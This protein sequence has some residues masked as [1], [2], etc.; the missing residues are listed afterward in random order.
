[1][2]KVRFTKNELKSRRD[3]L[4]LYKRFLPTLQ[5]KKKQLLSEVKQLEIRMAEKKEEDR[6]IRN[7]IAS[8]VKLFSEEVLPEY[9]PRIKDVKRGEGNIAGV[10]IPVLEDVAFTHAQIDLFDTP[11]WLDSA[12]SAM[13]TLMK[14]KIELE[15]MTEQRRLIDD[16]LTAT[17]QRVNLFE[18]VKIPEAKYHICAIT[19]FLGDMQ[20]AGVARA[21]L[22]KSKVSEAA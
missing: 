12:V 15:I 16:E 5:P 3:A 14:L 1:M 22:A 2:A 20:T 9:L 10:A 6:K 21:K 8:W 17:A 7:D 11:P 19:I 18:K 13:E 4:R